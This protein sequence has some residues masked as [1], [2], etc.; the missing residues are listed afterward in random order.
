MEPI[1]EKLRSRSRAHMRNI[2]K[3]GNLVPNLLDLPTMDEKMANF[4]LRATTDR[5]DVRRCTYKVHPKQYV[6]N[7]KFSTKK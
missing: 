5:A 3:R 7:R 4:F 6:P 2:S 1:L